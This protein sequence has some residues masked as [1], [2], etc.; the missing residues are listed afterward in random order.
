MRV[1]VALLAGVNRLPWRV[2]ALWNVLGAIV[3][4]TSVGVLAYYLGEA[5]QHDLLIGGLAAIG[6][7]V[8]WLAVHI[9]SHRRRAVR[10]SGLTRPY[11]KLHLPPAA[12]DFR[13][14][15]ATTMRCTSSGPS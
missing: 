8:V 7:V 5:I 2:F 3:W 11:S 6:V 9:S 14:R 12:N 1:V 10:T 13:I 15:R 4:A